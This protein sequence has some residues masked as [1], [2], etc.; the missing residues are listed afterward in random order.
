[1][2]PHKALVICSNLSVPRERIQPGLWKVPSG[3]NRGGRP[4]KPIPGPREATCKSSR[5]SFRENSSLTSAHPQSFLQQRQAH[6][7]H[8]RTSRALFTVWVSGE[9]SGELCVSFSPLICLGTVVS[10]AAAYKNMSMDEA[11]G[12]S[13]TGRAPRLSLPV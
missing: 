2:G 10:S 1:M 4:C 8:M 5:V 13:R 7:R 6:A 9:L 12:I 3:Q 11:K